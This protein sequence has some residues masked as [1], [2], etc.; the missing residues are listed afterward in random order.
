MS[1]PRANL[2]LAV[3][4][5]V[6]VFVGCTSSNLDEEHEAIRDR[7]K[8]DQPNRADRGL[9][10]GFDLEG[11]SVVA[12]GEFTA[13]EIEA[14]FTLVPEQG[15]P[16]GHRFLFFANATVNGEGPGL[17][18][19]EGD[20]LHVSEGRLSDVPVNQVQTGS[21]VS[22]S[23]S[24]GDVELDTDD[25]AFPEN[26]SEAAEDALFFGG[27]TDADVPQIRVSNYTSGY[28]VT[29]TSSSEVS[30]P[31]E[32]SAENMIWSENG[33]IHAEGA[34]LDARELALSGA[35]L[36]GSVEYGE[37][38]DTD[39]DAVFGHDG[40]IR[41]DP[42]QVRTTSP[43][44]VTQVVDD[45]RPRIEADVETDSVRDKVTVTEGDIEWGQVLYRETTGEG[46]ALLENVTVTGS[47]ADMVTVPVEAPP[48]IVQDLGEIV[49][50]SGPATPFVGLLVGLATPFVAVAEALDCLTGCPENSP[51][52]SWIDAGEVSSF[53]VK[54]EGNRSPGAYQAQATITG[55]NY[56]AVT[57]DWTI[58]VEAEDG[59]GN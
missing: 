27:Q 21:A 14:S 39:P 2:V 49:P 13:R 4:L 54:V 3:L 8:Q 1:N 24:T 17:L 47:G 51:F 15:F 50:E 52:P 18:L 6:P 30:G 12:T 53:F 48:S 9:E 33:T 41:V 37:R 16:E 29:A 43:L 5:V 32:V 20:R 28:L 36:T 35:N 22:L 19:L 26:V 23:T 42:G 45:D 59:G 57:L 56:D 55:E 10:G 44:R 58:Q 25:F 38:A 40:A 7:W 31:L 34:Q 46:D 11:D